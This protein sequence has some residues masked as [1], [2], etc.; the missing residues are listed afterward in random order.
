MNRSWVGEVHTSLDA[1][2]V[3]VRKTLPYHVPLYVC[4]IG[5]CVIS[6]AITETYGVPMRLG[7][8]SFFFGM[9]GEF[10]A[11]ALG[12]LA[13]LE[14]AILARKGFPAK[15]FEI[16][17]RQLSGWLLR[18]DRP[19]NIF[20]SLILFPILTISFCALKDNIP[21]INPFSWDKTFMQFDRWVSFGSTPWQ[22]LQPVLGPLHVTP[23]IKVAYNV[24]FLVLFGVLFWQAFSTKT[25]AK[26][27]QYLLAY[28]L[29]WFVAG[30]LLAVVFSSAGPCFYGRLHIG[31]DPYAAQMAFLRY[32][33]LHWPSWAFVMQDI[34]VQDLLWDM[35]KTRSGDLGGI[36]AMPSMHIVTSVLMMILAW[37]TNRKL[38]IAFTVFT[39]MIIV[40]SIRLGWHYVADDLAGIGLAALFWM[41]SGYVAAAWHR[42]LERT[43][44]KSEALMGGAIPTEA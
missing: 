37:S 33:S 27:L 5:F 12:L 28:S 6:F 32:R 26:R 10:A 2:A 15:P 41:V 24:W 38:G 19:G 4:A 31:P 8:G 36:S 43:R 16:I 22:V 42:Y 39:A 18:G 21:R 34:S 9:V 40:G 3:S 20:H 25:S 1:C 14:F 13:A 23:A 29:A 11:L 35:Y 7:A 17:G 44:P 30:N